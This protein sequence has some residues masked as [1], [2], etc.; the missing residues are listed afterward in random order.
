[1]SSP[2]YLPAELVHAILL[3]VNDWDAEDNRLKRGFTTCSLICRHWATVIRLLL[4]LELTLRSA[5]DVSKLLEFLEHPNFLGRP[6]RDCIR[7]LNIVNNQQRKEAPWVH[8]ILKLRGKFAFLNITVIPAHTSAPEM[9]LALTETNHLLTVPF[10]WLPKTLPTSRGFLR[11]LTL[12]N[13]RFPSIRVLVDAIARLRVGELTLDHISFVNQEIEVLRAR[14][15]RPTPEFY[16][17]VSRCF[18][19]A[20]DDLACWSRIANLLFASQGYA[21]LNDA[22]WELLDK[23]LPLLLSFIPED[24]SLQHLSVKEIGSIDDARRGYTYELHSEDKVISALSIFVVKGQPDHA[25]IASARFLCPALDPAEM[26]SYFSGLEDTLL[27]L[28]GPSPPLTN[29]VCPTRDLATEVLELLRAG[30]IFP[31]LFSV[32]RK[33]YVEA[34]TRDGQGRCEFFAGQI[35]ASFRPLAVDGERITLDKTQRVEWLLRRQSNGARMAYVRELLAT[36]RAAG[37]AVDLG[38]Q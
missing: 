26:P 4:F 8:H 30:A 13:I 35:V 1:M 22:A 33:V 20:A 32:Q 24:F 21:L 14:R 29:V 12:S 36:S 2:V 27:Q 7:M 11:S 16:L 17:T 38:G 25:E 3:Q 37:A 34:P 10:A 23:H 19:S 15:V 18:P 31:R 9:Q 5:E 28:N 6:L